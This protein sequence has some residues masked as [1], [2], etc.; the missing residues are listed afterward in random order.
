[1]PGG[2]LVTVPL[3]SP[4][5]VTVNVKNQV[6]GRTARTQSDR[7]SIV[8]VQDPAPEQ[9]PLQ[10][11]KV[12]SAA[13]FAVNVTVF[14]VGNRALHVFPQLMPLGALVTVPDPIPLFCTVSVDIGTGT[15]AVKI[16]VTV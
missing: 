5:L 7:V 8:T 2:S 14:P 3:P 6:T 15:I 9:A 10:P 1:M 4:D 13:G 16:A 11:T 12:E